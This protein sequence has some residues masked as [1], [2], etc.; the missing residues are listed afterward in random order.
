MFSTTRPCNKN[1]CTVLCSL[2]H[3]NVKLCWVR[4]QRIIYSPQCPSESQRGQFVASCCHPR[5]E[6]SRTEDGGGTDVKGQQ[7]SQTSNVHTQNTD[8]KHWTHTHTHTMWTQT[9][10]WDLGT[11][12]EC[13]HVQKGENSGRQTGTVQRPWSPPP[14]A[15]SLH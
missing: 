14:E 3:L 9:H 15:S 1:K 5:P 6:H 13:H 10:P 2:L 8:W 12:T 4:L 11:A 7:F